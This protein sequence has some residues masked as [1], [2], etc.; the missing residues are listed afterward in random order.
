MIFEI[1]RT[2]DGKASV[3]QFLEEVEKTGIRKS[4]PRMAN[5][6]KMLHTLRPYTLSSVED[7]KLDLGTFKT[8]IAEN[9]V[10]ITKALQ[11][12]L[13]IPAFETFCD[14]I[15]EIYNECLGLTSGTA[16]NYI[17]QLGRYDHTQFGVSICTVDGQ[18]F[19]LGDAATPFTVQSTCTPLTY[20]VCLNELGEKKVHEYQGRQP[21]GRMYNEIVLDYNNKPHNPLVNSG[22]IMSTALILSLVRDDLKD[23]AT[24]YEF[25]HAQIEDMAGGEHLG[26]NNSV[27]LAE[28]NSADRNFALAYFMRENN[29]FPEGID[30]K[31][32]LDFHFQLCSLEMTCESQSVVASTL[33]NGGI[34]PI[35]GKRI[36]GSEAVQNVR[37]LM[38]SCGMYNYSGQFAFDVGLPAKSG[39]SGAMMVVVPNVM[40]ISLWSPPL[41]VFGN[42][43]RGIRFCQELIKRYNF[44]RFDGVGPTDNKVDPTFKKFESASQA[45]I[46]ILMAAANGDTLALQRSW[47]QDIDLSVSDYDGRTALHLAAAEGHLESVK[48]L[49]EKCRVHPDPRDRW[50]RSPLS[51]AVLFEHAR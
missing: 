31:K 10:L 46:H 14:N 17:P 38:Y 28:R 16:A 33:A 44:H 12:Q 47:L 42:T 24:K 8:V 35:T 51:E 4:D 34:C 6:M 43:V 25:V 39:G 41:D 23:M 37:S 19:S 45:V 40:G 7:L 22:A 18:R 2:E 21:S 11:N 5:M 27:F 50:D 26:F 3:G 36:V 20:A 1:Y 48:F 9:V 32:A 29:C 30:I 13:V 49:L 15:T